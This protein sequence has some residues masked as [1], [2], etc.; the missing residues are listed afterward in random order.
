MIDDWKYRGEPVTKKVFV[1]GC[2]DLLHSGHVAF[3][4]EAASYGDL[5]VGL[6]S[7]ETIYGLKG[8]RTINNNEERLYMVKALRCVKDAWI[9]SG[10]GIMDFEK[11]VRELKP[12]IFF[13]NTDGYTP[14]K[15]AFCDELGIEL[16]VSKRVPRQGLP[17]RST[18]ARRQDCL[19]PYRVELCGG[20]LDQPSVNVLCPGSVIVM[21]I[22]PTVEFNDKS[23]MATSSRKKA[24]ELWQSRIPVGDR[25]QLAK[26]LFCV[27]NPPGTKAIS[28]SQDQLGL[29][30]PGLNKLNYDNGYWPKSIDSVTDD[31]SL[32]F[33]ADHLY[34]LQLPQR[35]AG[36]DVLGNTNIN[37]ASARKLAAAAEKCW[38]G[39]KA[40]D[41]RT[42]GEATRECF[43]AQLEMFPAMFTPEMAEAIS[44]YKDRACGWKVTGCGGGGYLL[45]ISEREIPNTIKVTP[46]PAGN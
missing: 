14:E 36:Y 19:I 21:S 5:Y 23:G 24:I 10:S 20:W 7:D 3:F 41:V 37:A 33:I 8:R 42:W 27:E 45:L 26:L 39:M 35:K 31:D 4:E 43:E 6:G 1:S 44:E 2:Y 13:V 9:S 28:G 17:A 22:E 38:Q 34:L 29:L 16:V 40:H 32:R 15:K 18:T 12:D 25:E 30:L 46:C 11:E